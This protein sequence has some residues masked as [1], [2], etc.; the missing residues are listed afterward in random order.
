MAVG[1][2][3]GVE[4][5][6]ILADFKPGAGLLTHKGADHARDAQRG[7]VPDSLHQVEFFVIAGN[8]VH[9]RVLGAVLRIVGRAGLKPDNSVD[10]EERTAV[11]HGAALCAADDINVFDIAVL[12]QKENIGGVVLPDAGHQHL[13]I[14]AVAAADRKLG[15]VAQLVPFLHGLIGHSAVRGNIVGQGAY[16]HL[17]CGSHIAGKPFILP[18]QDL[19]AGL[20]L[21]GVNI[22]VRPHHAGPGRGVHRHGDDKTACVVGVDGKVGKYIAQ[23]IQALCAHLVKLGCVGGVVAAV[24]SIEMLCHGAPQC[25]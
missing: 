13:Y 21:V 9:S 22:Y 20:P 12:G 23:P 3:A 25:F 5:R 2:C 4:V 11:D 10:A 16:R 6:L 17:A 15:L 18:V 19:T 8:A 1:V 24:V 7:G 14:V